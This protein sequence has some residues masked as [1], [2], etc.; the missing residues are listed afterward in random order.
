MKKLG[1]IVMLA[2]GMVFT[3]EAQQRRMKRKPN[4]TPEQKVELAVK[5]MTLELDLSARQQKEIT[6]L[7]TAQVKEREAHR[8]QRMEQRKSG[9]RPSSQELFAMQS[10]RL[11]KQIA[12]KKQMKEILDKDQFQR[13]EKMTHARKKEMR[14]KMK[15]RMEK[16]QKRRMMKRWMNDN[17]DKR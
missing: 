9:K 10:E 7:I 15:E 13:F 16:G 3:T 12:F 1:V 5:K 4:F 2:L 17:D 11:D 6:P 8:K 14:G